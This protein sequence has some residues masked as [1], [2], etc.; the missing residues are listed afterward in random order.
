M[1]FNYALAKQDG[2]TDQHI[3]EVL[4]EQQG[5]YVPLAL[6]DGFS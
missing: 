1:A 3:A 2:F 4:G 5:F 6:E